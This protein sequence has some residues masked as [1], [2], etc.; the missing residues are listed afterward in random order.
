MGTALEPDAK[1]NFYLAACRNALFNQNLIHPVTQFQ[2][3]LVWFINQDVSYKHHRHTNTFHQHLAIKLL[4]LGWSDSASCRET[5]AD[6]LWADASLVLLSLVGDV[7]F[8]SPGII[9]YSF[10]RHL[11]ISHIQT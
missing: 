8:H 10:F 4:V 11:L 2:G 1:H 5:F 9:S 7:L 3:L 6:Q